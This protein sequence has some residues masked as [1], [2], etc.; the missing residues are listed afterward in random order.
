M[1]PNSFLPTVLILLAATLP[2]SSHP[3]VLARPLPENVVEPSIQWQA[4]L[5]GTNW[6]TSP[7]VVF[8]D[9]QATGGFVIFGSDLA[10]PDGNRR[11]VLTAL[12]QGGHVLSER[13]FHGNGQDIATCGSRTPDGGYL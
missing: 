8:V 10:T 5:G 2:C 9:E 12:D 11:L 13:G 4:G 6:L 3:R 7:H 1:K